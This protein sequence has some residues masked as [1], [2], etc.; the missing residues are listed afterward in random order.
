MPD[1]LY[2]APEK[3]ATCDAME[4]SEPVEVAHSEPRFS[5]PTLRKAQ[6]RRFAKGWGTR[7]FAIT[8][9]VVPPIATR[10][11]VGPPAREKKSRDSSITIPP[12]PI[13]PKLVEHRP[14]Q[15]NQD[16]PLHPNSTAT[17]HDTSRHQE[18][19]IM[20]P[21]D[22]NQP[23]TE[24]KGADWRVALHGRLAGPGA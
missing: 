8:A 11:T 6:I 12:F 7:Y 10:F 1:P 22:G 24:G 14:A 5:V 4:E 2:A 15:G 17:K 13:F 9:W 16:A 20:P 3:G 21:I 18:G 23:R 19:R